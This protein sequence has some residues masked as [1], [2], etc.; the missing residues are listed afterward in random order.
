MLM[1]DCAN[2]PGSLIS[3]SKC[4]CACW[5]TWDNKTRNIMLFK[6]N[7]KVS[8][9][10][11]KDIYILSK[12]ENVL[13][14]QSPKTADKVRHTSREALSPAPHTSPTLRRASTRPARY[15]ICLFLTRIGQAVA[16]LH[17]RL[18]CRPWSTLKRGKRKRERRLAR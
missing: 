12:T 16:F 17:G 7:N 3:V 1:L 8:I 5:R 10:V 18:R 15:P 4:Q 6:R 11:W 9:W 2:A 14:L 13:S